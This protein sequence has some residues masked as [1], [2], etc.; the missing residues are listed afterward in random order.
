[1]KHHRREFDAYGE[2]VKR[3]EHLT[4]PMAVRKE[5]QADHQRIADGI[6]FAGA[7][8]CLIWVSVYTLI[9]RLLG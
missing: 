8:G 7:I 9:E 5:L 6:I 1:M 4:K 2:L 3:H